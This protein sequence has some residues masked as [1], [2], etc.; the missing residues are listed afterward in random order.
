[1]QTPSPEFRITFL[2]TA[3]SI[4]VPAIGCDCDVCQSDDPRNQRLRSSILLETPEQTWVVDTGPDFRQQCLRAGIRQLD[5]V[6]YTHPHVDHFIGFDELRRFCL[7][8]DKRI[9]IFGKEKCLAEIKRSFSY[10]FSGKNAY[11]AYVKPDPIAIESPMQ[12]GR[13]RVVPLPVEHGNVETI[14]YRFERKG[15]PVFAYVPDCKKMPTRTRDLVAG[16]DLLIIDA[17]RFSEHPSHMN[18]DEA[19]ELVGELQPRRALFT[20]FSCEI[21]HEKAEAG[22]PEN[23]NLAYD[24]LCV[25]L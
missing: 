1:M 2:G 15:A 6:F 19:L 12:I 3:T 10:A 14:G 17:M 11:Y 18:F 8:H 5:A 16:I 24:G 22:L 7:G 13:T 23:R 9:P 4:G 25:E 21:D 20:H